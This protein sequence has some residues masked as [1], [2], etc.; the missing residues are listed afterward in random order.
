MPAIADE[1]LTDQTPIIQD[2]DDGPEMDMVGLSK[3][4]IAAMNEED[5]PALAA[6]VDAIESVAAATPDTTTDAETEAA[7]PPAAEE[8]AATEPEPVY[9]EP[10][11]YDFGVTQGD[12]DRLTAIAAE[13]EALGEKVANG[14]IDFVE[15]N[16]ILNALLD[17][18]Q[19]I[20]IKVTQERIANEMRRQEDMRS[21]EVAQASFFHRPE[22]RSL[23]ETRA[24]F[25]AMDAAVKEIVE[26]GRNHGHDYGWLL[27]E[28]KKTVM[29][30]FGIPQ[31]TPA[32]PAAPP[33]KTAERPR[34][35]KSAVPV[36]LGDIPAAQSNDADEFAH[37]DKLDGMELEEVL[38]RMSPEAAERY[39]RQ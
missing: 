15:Y 33:T 34:P 22:N 26:S 11:P 4:E 36:T 6:V 19:S 30:A 21:W 9:Q 8:P 7:E 12:H 3:E 14:D 2:E 28:A 27:A 38:A 1:T 39:L 37:L 16:K 24:G 31:A 23:V 18:K 20:E 13:R 10:R 17:E 29:T 35:G 32:S 5:D 25:A